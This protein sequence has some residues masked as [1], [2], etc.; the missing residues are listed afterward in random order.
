MERQREVRR[1]VQEEQQRVQEVRR[2]EQAPV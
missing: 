1:P 2:A